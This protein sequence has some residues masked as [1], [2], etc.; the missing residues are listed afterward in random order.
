MG[1]PRAVTA[2]PRAVIAHPRAVSGRLVD[3]S[4][5]DTEISH[6]TVPRPAAPRH[7]PRARGARGPGARDYNR[8]L[9]S[10]PSETN[11]AN[12]ETRAVVKPVLVDR[13]RA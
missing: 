4:R 13:L 1:H 8:P 6:A 7:C 10:P 2:H 9:S 5:M 12:Y 3:G 11:A